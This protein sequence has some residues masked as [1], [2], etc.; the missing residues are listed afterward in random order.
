MNTMKSFYRSITSASRPQGSYVEAL[1]EITRMSHEQ[2]KALQSDMAWQDWSQQNTEA[3]P[4][5]A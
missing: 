1:A 5:G 4:H 3:T 2:S